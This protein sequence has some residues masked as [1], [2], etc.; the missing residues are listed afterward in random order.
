VTYGSVCSGI[1][2]VSVA[3]RPLGWRAAWL[4]EIEPFPSRVLA[5]H[6]PETPNLGD[7]TTIAA[8]IAA[9]EVDAPDLLVGGTPC[10]SFSVAG[11]RRGLS[12]ERG[13]LALEFVRLADAISARVPDAWTL[14]ENVP[15]VL[16]DK[17]NA[18]GCFLA[19][20]VGA[21]APL[22]SRGGWRGAGVVAGP[23]R[24]AAW[25]IL[26]AQF[27]GVAQRRRR[28]FVL[29]R[30]GAGAWACADA[31]LPLGPRLPR[32]PPTR[33]AQG[34]EVAGTLGGGAQ[35]RGWCDDLDRAGAFVPGISPALKARDYKGPS[36]DGDGDGAPLIARGEARLTR[37]E[38]RT[39]LKSGVEG[40]K[41]LNKKM[42]SVF[43]PNDV[44]H[45]LRAQAQSAH[46]ASLE[47]YVTHSLRGEGFDASEDGTGRG[48]PLVPVARS[49]SLRGREGGGTAEL[50]DGLAN[51]LRASQGGGDKPH[52]L[53]FDPNQITS[54]TNRSNPQPG[55]AAPPL[56]AFGSAP[57]IAEQS[58]GCFDAR[59]QLVSGNQ[60]GGGN[61]SW[62]GIEEPHQTLTASDKPNAIVSLPGDRG[63]L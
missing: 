21:D 4:A 58:G 22:V 56:V 42:A 39:R 29:A 52:V 6:Y 2:A 10:Q 30:G 40:A 1:E 8:R 59:A 37:E 19:G 47:T 27:F 48:T 5:H 50:G 61:R 32:D 53:A 63:L 7:M 44:A 12:D 54:A 35:K 9:G 13:N 11:L 62:L 15:G 14:W 33:R 46:D 57:M 18:F 3:W 16:S 38:L 45:S 51:A 28:V 34:E 60:G 26:D 23:R 41:E 36:S 43:T 25:R 17:G 55:D 49:V 31:L 20:L 24:V